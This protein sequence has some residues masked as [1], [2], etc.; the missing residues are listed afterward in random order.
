MPL[1][2]QVQFSWEVDNIDVSQ[3]LSADETIF[4]ETRESNRLVIPDSLLATGHT[5][6]VNV[7]VT[8]RM[9]NQADMTYNTNSKFTIRPFDTIHLAIQGCNRSYGVNQTSNKSQTVSLDASASFDPDN[10]AGKLVLCLC[11]CS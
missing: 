4:T 2:H 9:S 3:L 5:Y 6:N 11:L 7:A 1:S 10:S 8:F